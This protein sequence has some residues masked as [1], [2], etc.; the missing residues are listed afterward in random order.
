MIISF[1]Q[2]NLLAFAQTGFAVLKKG[3]AGEQILKAV[4]KRPTNGFEIKNR[5]CL[6]IGD[7]AKY[8]QTIDWLNLNLTITL[9][10]K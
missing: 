6:P 1:P 5:T 2:T 10:D 4:R 7:T 3:T 8:Q 9:E